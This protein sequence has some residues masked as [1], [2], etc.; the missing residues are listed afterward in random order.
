MNLEQALSVANE[1]FRAADLQRGMATLAGLFDQCASREAERDLLLAWVAARVGHPDPVFGAH[2]AVV[3]GAL[4]EHGASAAVLGRAIIAPLEIA[5]VNAGR[6]LER[7]AT[8]ADEPGD[9]AVLVGERHLSP[10]TI[11]AL[12]NDDLDAVNAW[13]SLAT[14]F[15]PAVAAW[16]R[17][18]AVLREV[19]ANAVLRAALAALG[20]TT[21][22]THWLSLL[23]EAVFDA[24]F[25][26]LVP[27]LGEA[28]S[29]QADGVVD[30]GQLTVLLSE[31]LADPLARIG[32]AGIATREVLDLMTGAGPQRDEGAYASSCAFYPIEAIDPEDGMPRD[33]VHT[34][35]APGG[36]GTDSLP[37]DFL[38]G[39]LPVRDGERLLV[40]VGP[41]APGL[42]VERVIPAVR[43]F[44][45]LA[46]RVDD[47]QRLPAA[48]AAR[49]FGP[50]AG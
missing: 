20:S 22:T 28:W 7:A 8:L 16:T 32:A 29:F 45:A 15:R 41:R 50:A 37:P 5:L 13:L 10:A 11:N 35:T 43:T 34:W 9:E 44:D 39:T 19:Q 3:G 14:W 17:E 23:G 24:R 4:V 25:V 18:P 27:E 49:W 21:E 1:F 46:A 30:L 31:A 33:G 36:S 6:L 12:A 40:L 47:V 26:V 48:Q 38:P 2:I 42:R